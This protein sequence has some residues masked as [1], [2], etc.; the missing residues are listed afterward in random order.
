MCAKKAP[1][2]LDFGL[3]LGMG[4]NASPLGA[5]DPPADRQCSPPCR[6]QGWTVSVEAGSELG[7]AAVTAPPLGP[8]RPLVPR[9]SYRQSEARL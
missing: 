6:E 2:L 3:A 7:L 9:T 5:G 8:G 4:V 1:H